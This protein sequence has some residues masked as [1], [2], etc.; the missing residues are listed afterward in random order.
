VDGIGGLFQALA[1][2]VV[3]LFGGAVRAFGEAVQGVFH[4]FQAILPGPWLLIVGVGVVIYLFWNFAK[5]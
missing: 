5:R 2:A 3:G 1:S 4:T